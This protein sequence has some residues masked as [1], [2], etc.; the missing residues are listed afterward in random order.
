M[1]RLDSGH[2][3][4]GV[5]GTEALAKKRRHLYVQRRPAAVAPR[6]VPPWGLD[7]TFCAAHDVG[8]R[9]AEDSRDCGE[10]GRG[11]RCVSV[12]LG[13]ESCAAHVQGERDSG[14]RHV[15]VA[16]DL[17]AHLCCDGGVEASGPISVPCY[18]LTLVPYA[19][20][21]PDDGHD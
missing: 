8:S 19:D 9:R 2:R 20:L 4:S 15:A 6:G 14:D 7:R 18:D 1:A 3:S 10:K 13:G 11:E 21:Y 5:V 17:C 12:H 16:A